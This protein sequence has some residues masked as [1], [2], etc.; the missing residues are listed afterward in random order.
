MNLVRKNQLQRL[1]KIIQ[2]LQN[3][4]LTKCELIDRLS[5]YFEHSFSE[6]QIEKDIFCLRMDFDAPIVY[7]KSLK[8]YYIDGDYDFKE[9][10]FNYLGL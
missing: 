3:R 9:A 7:R 8:N 6:S 10:L 4:A 1:S 2:I 5:D